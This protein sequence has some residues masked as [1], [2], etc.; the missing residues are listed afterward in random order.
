MMLSTI[1]RFVV[2]ALSPAFSK[3]LNNFSTFLWSSLSRVIASMNHSYPVA[4]EVNVLLLVVL[5]H[6][7]VS[8]SRRAVL[9]EQ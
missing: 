3:R 1:A 2:W 4:R 8:R 5:S 6:G 7:P 9:T